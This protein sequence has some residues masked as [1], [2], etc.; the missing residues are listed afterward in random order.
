MVSAITAAPWR[1]AMGKTLD[2]RFSPSP[3]DGIDDGLAGNALQRFFDHVRLGRS[4]PVWAR[5]PAWRLF[6]ESP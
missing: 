1:L 4:P 5:A 2:V 3:D 6:Q